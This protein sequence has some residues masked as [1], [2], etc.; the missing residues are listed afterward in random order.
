MALKWKRDEVRCYRSGLSWPR[1]ALERWL[2]RRSFH[3]NVRG[4]EVYVDGTIDTPTDLVARLEGTFT[5]L[6]SK[7][8]RIYGRFHESF[9]RFLIRPGGFSE[10]WPVSRSCILD[11]DLLTNYPTYVIAGTL[12]HEHTHARL[13]T[14]Q[15]KRDEMARARV[16]RR[17]IIEQ[18]AIIREEPRTER[19]VEWLEN[20]LVSPGASNRQIADRRTKGLLGE[21]V[22]TWIVGTIRRLLSR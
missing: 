18:L 8:G 19:Y 5:Y 12:V 20:R 16:E 7:H 21:G 9:E 2:T 4:F 10:Y 22:P 3:R 14:T 6:A 11:S 1:I 15:R 13:F 17:C